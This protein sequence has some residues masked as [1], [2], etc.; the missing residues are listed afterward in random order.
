[1]ARVFEGKL[2]AG[3]LRLAI[4]ASRFNALITDRL[5][6]GA[7]DA[8]RRTGGD[9]DAV[10]VYRTP[11]AFEI[12]AVAQRLAASGRFDALIC[13]GAV[14]RGDT[15]HHEHIAA[16]VTKGVAQVQLET[17]I[18][19]GYGV[20]TPDTLEQALERAGSKGGNKGFDAALATIELADLFRQLDE[21]TPQ[22][23]RV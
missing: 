16:E 1:M 8:V 17:G 3:G 6:E 22:P 14:I 7:L 13:L 10:Q 19:I 9:A 5:I 12:P 23:D 21:P 18:P 4:V 20:I 15:P 11:G 2:A